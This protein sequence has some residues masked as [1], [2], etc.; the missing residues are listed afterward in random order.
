MA[1]TIVVVEQVDLVNVEDI[2]VGLGQDATAQA[3]PFVR[4]RALFDES[5]HVFQA[6]V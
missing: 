1:S 3:H 4:H 6:G 5:D 2:A